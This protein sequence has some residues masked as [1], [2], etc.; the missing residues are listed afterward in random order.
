[1]A[2]ELEELSERLD[3]A[4]GATAAQMELNK[5]RENEIHKMRKDVE[6]ASIMR[7]ATMGALKKKH[8]DAVS[9]MNEQIEQL[10]RMKNK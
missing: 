6:E 3:E 8:Q 7:E 2:R 10:A 1:M 9:E 5:K 4:G